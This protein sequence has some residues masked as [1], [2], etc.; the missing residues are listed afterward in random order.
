MERNS[1]YLT[2]KDWNIEFIKMFD[3][4]STSS[5]IITALKDLSNT[6]LNDY[7]L[8]MDFDYDEQYAGEGLFGKIKYKKEWYYSGFKDSEKILGVTMICEDS[9]EMIHLL[10]M[11]IDMEAIKTL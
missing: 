1:F 10:Q 8:Y 9:S 2:E 7:I 6:S 4:K 3:E 5:R 11:A